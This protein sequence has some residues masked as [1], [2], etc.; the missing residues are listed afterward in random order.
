[1]SDVDKL[2]D[3][4]ISKLRLLI[5]GQED[6]VLPSFK[7][8]TF[9]DLKKHMFSYQFLS[10]ASNVKDH[11]TLAVDP[12]AAVLKD[13]LPQLNLVFKNVTHRGIVPT[14]FV[15]KQIGNDLVESS[16]KEFLT[17]DKDE[18]IFG[19]I[20]TVNFGGLTGFHTNNVLSLFA[21]LLQEG[22]VDAKRLSRVRL[23]LF[24]DF[25]VYN[26]EKN[27]TFKNSQ[28]WTL[29]LSEVKL[30]GKLQHPRKPMELDLKSFMDERSLVKEAVDL[31]IKLMKWRL[32]PSLDI[33]KIQSKRCLL[34]GAGTLGC[35]LA[36]NLIG[37]GVKNISFVDYSKVSYSN[38]VRQTLYDYED[39]IKG[40]RPKA[41]VAAE[42]L[43]K[44]YPEIVSEGYHVSVPMP[45]HFVTTKELIDETFRNLDL[46]EKLVSE[47]DVL[48]LLL[49]SREA[50]WLPTLLANKYDKACIT[51]GLGFDSFVIVRHGVSP[52]IYDKEKHRERLSCYFCNDIVTPQDTMKD[53]T[54]DQMCTVTRPGLSFTSSAYAS[55]LYISMIH[56]PMEHHVWANEDA[57][58]L[59]ET[60]LGKLPH[61][62]RGCMSEFEVSIFY[63]RAFEQCVACS[64]FVLDEYNNN[65]E[66]FMLHVLNNPSYIHKVTKLED[67]I[68]KMEEE[69]ALC[70]DVIDD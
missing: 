18:Y 45:G 25:M 42:K 24:K 16:L 33:P 69:A 1:M 53:R 30:N 3:G 5:D 39:S 64:K 50:R 34:F 62:L 43:K 52:A 23:L 44:I 11:K 35:Q 68:R 65:R 57:K 6:L 26:L 38:P 55:E 49:D 21:L 60:D 19:C 20:D 14:L 47:H 48:F 56:H 36:R 2:L 12:A 61:H 46:I 41:I 31:N 10:V 27:Y 15:M 7:L 37:W 40:G 8:L 22:K 4:V 29:D 28:L 63:G 17:N 66:E 32:L 70:F 51:V 13:S 67:D 54:L 58:K 59:E 9:A